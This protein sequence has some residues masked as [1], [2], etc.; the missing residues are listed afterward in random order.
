MEVRIYKDNDLKAY[1]FSG[2]KNPLSIFYKSLFFYNDHLWTSVEIVLMHL[3]AM[4]F[5]DEEIAR[6]LLASNISTSTAKKLGKTIKNYDEEKWK[7]TIKEVLPDI[8]KAKFG[9]NPVLWRLLL[10]TNDSILAEMENDFFGVVVPEEEIAVYEK[11]SNYGD[12][13]LGKC[14]MNLR[15]ELKNENKY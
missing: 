9:Q 12:N 10:E 14:L 15:N 4:T 3:K 11:W 5:N 8:L 7:N 2:K 13:Y 6:K 1:G